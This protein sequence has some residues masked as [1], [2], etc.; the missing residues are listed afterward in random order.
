MCQAESLFPPHDFGPAWHVS[1]H[2]LDHI[3]EPQLSGL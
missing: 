3:T 2:I 1:K